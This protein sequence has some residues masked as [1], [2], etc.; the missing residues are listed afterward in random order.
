LRGQ[1][2]TEYL[3]LLAVVLIVA[4]VTIALLGFFPGTAGD[5]KITESKTY[6]SGVA[7]P[8]SIKDAQPLYTASQG[9]LC[10]EAVSRGVRMV[11]QNTQVSTLILTSISFGGAPVSAFCNPGA[12]IGAESIPLGPGETTVVDAVIDADYCTAARQTTDVEIKL[13]YNT[14]YLSGQVQTGAKNLVYKC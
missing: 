3:V 13:D 14:Q 9:D 8:I 2:A 5:A 10:G 6:W 12:V 1:G 11:L 4:T 7:S